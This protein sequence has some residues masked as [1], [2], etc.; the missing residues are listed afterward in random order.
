MSKP[1]SRLWGEM[2]QNADAMSAYRA[3]V[4]D[5]EQAGGVL[6]YRHFKHGVA[7]K[8]IRMHF[9]GHSAGSIVASSMI[10][11]LVQDGMHFE[12][13]SFMASAVMQSAGVLVTS[14]AGSA[15]A[16]GQHDSVQVG[17]TG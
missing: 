8:R 16:A 15:P 12:S 1:G 6:L 4:P 10:D 13:V 9:V 7:N 2:K 17:N 5:D 3:D 11:R 14:A